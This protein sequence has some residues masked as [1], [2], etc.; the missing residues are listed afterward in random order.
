MVWAEATTACAGRIEWRCVG[1][2]GVADTDG[3]SAVVG[4][5]RGDQSRFVGGGRGEVDCDA[6]LFDRPSGE[7]GGGAVEADV[8]L[9]S[10]G[11]WEAAGEEAVASAERIHGSAG[12][13]DIE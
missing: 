13:S 12:G 4:C 1:G 5:L 8:E 3:V 2:V 9:N 11:S 6:G 7:F 10:S